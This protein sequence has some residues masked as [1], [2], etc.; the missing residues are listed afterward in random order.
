VPDFQLNP[1]SFK[2]SWTGGDNPRGSGIET[3]EVQTRCWSSD[4]SI[5]IIG[6][7]TQPIDILHD[8][9]DAIIPD[10]TVWVTETTN[11]S[12]MFYASAQGLYQFRCHA[13]DRAGNLELYPLI[14]DTSIYVVDLRL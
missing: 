13:R 11:T 6:C 8:A 1:E 4:V 3:F 10:W 7:R 14:A 9:I 2:V 12:S 5:F